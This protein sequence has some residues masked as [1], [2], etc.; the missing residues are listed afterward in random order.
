MTQKR[1]LPLPFPLLGALLAS[2]GDGRVRRLLWRSTARRI[3]RD[4]FGNRRRAA[5]PPGLR[6]ATLPR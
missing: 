4:Q 6:P 5:R 3:R 2:A 1:V